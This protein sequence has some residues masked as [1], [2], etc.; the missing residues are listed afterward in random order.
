MLES[1][2]GD[3]YHLELGVRVSE[4]FLAKLGA[5]DYWAACGCQLYYTKAILGTGVWILPALLEDEG[6]NIQYP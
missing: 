4:Y 2:S 1:D 5:S 3:N 6:V